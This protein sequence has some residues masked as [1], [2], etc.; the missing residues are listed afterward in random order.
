[1]S[2][3]S[4]KPSEADRAMVEPPGWT[5]YLMAIAGVAL[6]IGPTLGVLWPR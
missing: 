6:L 4:Q 1:M 5:Q 2:Q 3:G